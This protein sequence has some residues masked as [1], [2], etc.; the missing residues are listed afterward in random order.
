[1]RISRALAGIGVEVA[2]VRAVDGGVDRA[3]AGV[4]V[5]IW[6]FGAT[7]VEEYQRDGDADIIVKSTT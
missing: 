5:A 1:M 6:R 4:T 2:T 7:W 3:S